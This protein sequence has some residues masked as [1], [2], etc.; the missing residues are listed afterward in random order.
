[1]KTLLVKI[2]APVI[3]T[4]STGLA[5]NNHK[6]VSKDALINVQGYLNVN[7]HCIASSLCSNTGNQICTV[8]DVNGAPQLFGRNA[9]GQCIIILFRPE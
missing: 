1:M 7:G 8:G 9:F 2:I 6:P 4:L 5:M 3:A